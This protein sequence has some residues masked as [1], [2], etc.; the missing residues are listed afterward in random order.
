MS[1]HDRSND[2]LIDIAR[3][4]FATLSIAPS[5]Q[6]A[7]LAHLI[8]WLERP[9]F[10]VYRPQ[11][12]AMLAAERW[13]NLLDSFYQVLPFG[14]GGRRGRVGIG[15]NRFNPWT[16]GMSVQG[17]AAWLHQEFEGQQI[18]VV[19]ANDVRCFQDLEGQLEPGIP[20]PVLGLSSRDFAELAA[21]IYAAAEITALL[22][23]EG[24]PMSTPELSFAIRELGAHGGLNISASHNPPD[25]NGGKF[26]N[27]TGGQEVP[28][29]DEQMARMVESIESIDRMPLDRARVVGLVQSQPDSLYPAYLQ[30]NLECS[31]SPM[32]RSARVVFTALH[33]TGRRTVLPVL[34]EA[35]F[36]AL[37]EPTQAEFDGSFPEVPF[38]FPNPE[39]VQ[40]LDRA[41]EFAEAKGAHLVM[42]CDPDADRIGLAAREKLPGSGDSSW[43]VFNGNEIAALVCHYLLSRQAFSSQPLV[44]KTEV[45]SQ[46]ISRVSRMHGGRTIG[47]LLVG[48]K[49][50]GDA[51]D[52]LERTGRFANR[53]ASLGQFVLGAEE[54]HGILVTTKVRDKDAAGAALMLA[55]LASTEADEGRTLLDTLHEIWGRAGYVRNELL[56]TVMRGAEGRDRIQRIQS[57][58]RL[59]PP[60]R[61]GE[62]EVSAFHDRQSECGVFGPISSETERASRDVLVFEL[63]ENARVVLRPSGTEPK[64]KVYVEMADAPEADGAPPSPE[65][66][67]HIEDACRRLGEDFVLEMLSRVDLQLP[68]WALRASDLLSVEHKLELAHRIVPQLSV[69]LES[70]GL[71]TDQ[72]RSWLMKQLSPMGPDAILLVA[73][74]LEAWARQENPTALSALPS[75]L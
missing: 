39:V 11:I 18:K 67:A 44:I 25:D 9:V 28:P 35:G 41:I 6:E 47:H 36:E 69:R 74:A 53:P 68:R 20:S 19:L 33:G 5:I 73:P 26:Y 27:S 49:Y 42:A 3:I 38:R 34:Q 51:L 72:T 52:Q 17:H 66:I 60:T 14:T 1:I 8:E 57:S 13:A 32:A 48:F 58:L 21:E 37:L 23:P 63:G 29:R 40:S 56:S 54:S 24:V 45:T 59:D 30:A 15:P 62:L 22:P 4:G 55:E 31:R 2:E 10:Q 70:A 61:I 43:R 65:R 46:L 16:L 71:E 75:L 50:I 12:L 7:A 64:N